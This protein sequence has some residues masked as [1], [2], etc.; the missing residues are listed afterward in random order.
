MTLSGWTKTNTS[1]NTDPVKANFPNSALTT[2]PNPV[3]PS[4]T[5]LKLKASVYNPGTTQLTPAITADTNA[6][7][8]IKKHPADIKTVT[9]LCATIT[10][11]I[12]DLVKLLTKKATLLFFLDG[13]RL[14][15]LKPRSPRGCIIETKGHWSNVGRWVFLGSNNFSETLTKES[16]LNP[17]LCGN[18]S[19]LEHLPTHRG[20]CN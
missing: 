6:T 17:N 1:A 2:L 8:L 9:M 11:K 13:T 4:V 19:L 16:Y 18:P 20:S 12:G 14:L 10:L 7:M 3:L 15:F 5:G